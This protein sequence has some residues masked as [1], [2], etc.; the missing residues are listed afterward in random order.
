M[1]QR[2]AVIFLVLIVTGFVLVLTRYTIPE[3]RQMINE[4]NDKN[5]AGFVELGWNVEKSGRLE[6]AFALYN[7]ALEYDPKYA[8]AYKHR[9]INYTRRGAFDQAIADFN[10][11][12]EYD[13]KHASSYYNL[14]NLYMGALD[15]N[16]AIDNFSK[17]IELNP[18]YTTALGNRAAMYSA[19]KQYAKALADYDR[20]LE[21]A[22]GN[23][24]VLMARASVKTYLGKE[25]DALSDIEEV[26]RLNPQDKDARQYKEF[27]VK[28]LDSAGQLGASFRTLNAQLGEANA[29]LGEGKALPVVKE[30]ERDPIPM[31]FGA[32]S[33]QGPAGWQKSGETVL[34]NGSKMLIEY[35]SPATGKIPVI[36][37]SKD[38]LGPGVTTALEF[39]QK[40][41]NVMLVGL[42]SMKIS[43]PVEKTINGQ[44]VSYMEFDAKGMHDIE[45]RFA[46]YQFLVKDTIVTLQ[47]MNS[48][49]QFQE[50]LAVFN[51]V[52]DSITW[53]IKSE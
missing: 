41:R 6:E 38:R 18:H 3:S 17:A 16:K 33:I 43:E 52:A 45:Y 51:A 28:S 44:K 32:M 34:S 12:I 50:G 22:P 9:A 25:K 20:Y 31:P 14:G 29:L 10:K 40:M 8:M 2:N 23:K 47:Y 1:P 27:L 39:S 24:D 35:T 7:K 42:P 4:S 11:A 48:D 36:A 15:Y 37:V 26:L 46:W 13:P 19:T 49:Y 30:G 5:A 53:D 21:L